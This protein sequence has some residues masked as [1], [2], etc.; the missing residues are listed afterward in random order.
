MRAHTGQTWLRPEL[1]FFLFAL[2]LGARDVG[3][4]LLFKGDAA[5]ARSCFAF[6]ICLVV[7][8]LSLFFIVLKRGLRGLA[9]K[10]L[11][12][13]ILPRVLLVGA[14]AAVVYLVTFEMIG[15]IGAGLFDLFDYGLGPIL[16]GVLGVLL[17]QNVLTR[18]FLLAALAYAAGVFF[19]FW[20]SQAV[21]WLWLGVGLLSPVGTS[22]SDATTKWLISE[23]GGNMS[24]S[25]LLFVRF[26]PATVLIGMWILATG[27]GIHLHYAGFSVPLT[28]ICGFVPLWLLCTGLGR[29]ALTKYAV[30][31]FLIPA[32]A[33][34]ATL[35]LHPEHLTLKTTSGAG[36]IILAVVLHE[37]NWH[38]CFPS[39]RQQAHCPKS[40]WARYRPVDQL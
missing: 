4:E 40:R 25:E 21:S 33:F 26:L 18:R 29:A 28:V 16:T 11:D 36:I 38:P 32:V 34:F 20:G 14:S 27:G 37:I 13:R 10:L 15:R 19:L 7:T 8:A 6:L 1:A 23:D 3:A 35:P 24:R 31:E 12:P 22:I 5:E 30:W 9:R 2:L 39:R 17:F